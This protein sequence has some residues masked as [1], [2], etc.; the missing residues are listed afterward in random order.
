VK[1]TGGDT[2][3]G[4]EDFD[5]SVVEHVAAVLKKDH[6]LDTK[7]DPKLTRKLRTAV[8]KAKRALSSGVSA[9][10]EV[11]ECSV[12]LTRA[13]FEA[14]NK[15]PFDRTLDTVKKVL[16]DAK[17]EAHEIDDIVLIGGSTRIPRIQE[18]LSQF[19]GGRQL[20]RSINPDEA[21]AYG[22][23]V[24]GAILSGKRFA[25]TQ[26]LLLVDVTPLS[27]GIEMEGKVFS[28]LIPRNTSIPCKKSHTY[29][30]TE[31]YQDSIEICVYE[32]ERPCTDG[33]RL[34]GQF[35]IHN[36]ERA[37]RGEPQIEV[38]FALDANGILDVA[39]RDKKTCAQAD[40]R[41]DGACKGLDPKEVAKMVQEAEKFASQDVEYRKQ[42]EIKAD[43]EA[44]AY[45][46][47]DRDE[48]S[49]NIKKEAVEKAQECLDWLETSPKLGSPEV[50]REM[51]KMLR[52][53][54]K[55]SER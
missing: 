38:T 29:T 9:Q 5:N 32:G 45:D 52:E 39:A 41:I 34:L 50:G 3:L 48:S 25:A 7:S 4:G 22:A 31:D 36:V 40:C 13:K 28:V 14:L 2:H 46:I 6:G 55:L 1:A 37:K 17:M 16:K 15:A 49:G 54:R 23:A 19:F 35:T 42:L 24:Q 8:E 47:Q 53:L 43:L 30:T 33:N 27:L 20:C 44:A 10:V 21:V 11:E 26:A 12:E 51:E 18:M